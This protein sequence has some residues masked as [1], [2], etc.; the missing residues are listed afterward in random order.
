[1]KRGMMKSTMVLITLV[2]IPVVYSLF[3]REGADRGAPGKRPESGGRATGDGRRGRVGDR[4]VPATGQD[5]HFFRVDQPFGFGH[6]LF[7]LG[8][9]I[10]VEQLDF[11]TAQSLDAAGGVD[12]LRG[13]LRGIDPVVAEVLL[14]QPVLFEPIEPVAADA[15]RV[16]LDLHL[17]VPGGRAEGAGDLPGADDPVDNA[18]FDIDDFRS[19]G[20]EPQSLTD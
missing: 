17:D 15:F 18:V 11:G 20:V 9:G 19:G 1:M 5:M 4:G 14:L 3:H 10:G 7:G 6:A 2:L 8:F 13:E 16:E 12:L